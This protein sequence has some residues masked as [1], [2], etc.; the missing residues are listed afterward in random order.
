MLLV[1]IIIVQSTIPISTAAPTHYV[2]S[3][4]HTFSYTSFKK[5]FQK[6]LGPF[7]GSQGLLPSIFEFPFS[8][9]VSP[10]F[11]RR[12]DLFSCFILHGTFFH[13]LLGLV[14]I[15]LRSKVHGGM[16]LITYY[17]YSTITIILQDGGVLKTCCSTLPTLRDQI[18]Q[19]PWRHLLT[20]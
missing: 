20:T 4:T 9:Y 8:R 15:F 16:N 10:Y 1:F 12:F 18:Y 14:S 13:L 11:F 17:Y 6:L 19:S 7:C 2:W 5:Y 3:S